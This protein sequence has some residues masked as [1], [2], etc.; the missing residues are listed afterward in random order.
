MFE[1]LL[2]LSAETSKTQKRVLTEEDIGS[3]GNL[4]Q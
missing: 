2:S 3:L 4:C 1:S